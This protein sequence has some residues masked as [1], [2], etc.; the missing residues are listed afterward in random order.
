[1]YYEILAERKKEKTYTSFEAWKRLYLWDRSSVNSGNKDLLQETSPQQEIV[2]QD[3]E[4]EAAS[5]T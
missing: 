2:I 5:K 4:N 3:G 1:M